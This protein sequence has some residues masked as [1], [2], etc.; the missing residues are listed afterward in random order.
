MV[1]GLWNMQTV[2]NL[3]VNG[4]MIEPMATEQC[5]PLMVIVTKATG[6]MAKNKATVVKPTAMV[7]NMMVNGTETKNMAKEHFCKKKKYFHSFPFQEI[8]NFFQ[9]FFHFVFFHGLF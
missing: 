8:F 1:M 5:P 6:K 3:K 9:Y 7:A 4:A 2:V